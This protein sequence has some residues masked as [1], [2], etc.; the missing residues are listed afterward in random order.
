MAVD[1]QEPVVL[2]C[3]AVYP[4]PVLTDIGPVFAI[5]TS[6]ATQRNKDK[7]LQFMVIVAVLRQ[8]RLQWYGHVLQKEDI[9]WVKNVWNIRWRA[10]LPV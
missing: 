6:A 9:D 2:R 7:L 3:Y 10:A 8:N 4:L 1:W 5:K